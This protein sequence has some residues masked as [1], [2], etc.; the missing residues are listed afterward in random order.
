MSYTLDSSLEVRD[1]YPGDWAL[2]LDWCTAEGW[3]ISEPER[4][5]LQN[6]WRSSFKV[7]WE[8]TSAGLLYL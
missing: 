8:K 6:R 5:L 1:V 7:L 3:I 2:F 4:Y